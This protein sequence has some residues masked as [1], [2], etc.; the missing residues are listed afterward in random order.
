MENEKRDKI[1][2][3]GRGGKKTYDFCLDMLCELQKGKE[4]LVFS[5]NPIKIQDAFFNY[6]GINLK[7]SPIKNETN[8]YN[9]EL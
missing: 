2:Y 8:I 9:A 7:L 4:C 1:F 5:L 6:T 3:S